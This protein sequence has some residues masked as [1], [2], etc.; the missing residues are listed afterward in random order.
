MKTVILSRNQIE[1]LA[2]KPFPPKTA[3]IS[4]TDA[5]WTYAELQNKP[6]FLLQ[7]E[8]WVIF[9]FHH[10]DHTKPSKDIVLLKE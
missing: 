2:Q 10:Y 7:L 3:V 9:H 4:I 5:E 6:E 1:A 8:F